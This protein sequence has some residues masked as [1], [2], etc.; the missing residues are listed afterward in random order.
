MT[1]HSI[2][3]SGALASKFTLLSLAMSTVQKWIAALAK[4]QARRTAVLHLESL[5]D[6]LLRDIGIERADIPEA[7]RRDV[8]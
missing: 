3:H 8:A 6:R 5:D 1:V 4:V 7:V 2:P